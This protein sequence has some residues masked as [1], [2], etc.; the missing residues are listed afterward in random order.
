M[1]KNINIRSNDELR[2]LFGSRDENL[3]LIED[4]LHLK[5]INRQN[6]LKLTGSND[7]VIKGER[8]I[9]TLLNRLREGVL[10]EKADILR[11][12]KEK[13]RIRP[14]DHEKLLESR[15]EVAG[16][17]IITIA[18]KTRG[19]QEYIDAIKSHDIVF[20]I[21]PA[22]T[23]KTYLAMATAVAALKKGEVRRIILT[24]PAI[25]AG[26]SLGFLPGDMYEKISPYLRPL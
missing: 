9:N 1:E 20:G 7:R 23:G 13:G 21:G 8:L 22:G 10:I 24:R 12:L 4:S 5:I 3:R 17:N 26:E 16:K 15:I 18:P 25:E 6:G 2:L 11:L 19:Q 14:P